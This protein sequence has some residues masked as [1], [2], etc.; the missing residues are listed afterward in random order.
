MSNTSITMWCKFACILDTKIWPIEPT[1]DEFCKKSVTAEVLLCNTIKTGK[2]LCF[3][4]CIY[5]NNGIE[6]SQMVHFI[7]KLFHLPEQN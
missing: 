6:M 3:P 1:Y 5:H 7:K 4:I 2:I